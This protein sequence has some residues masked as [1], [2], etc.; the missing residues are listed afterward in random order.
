[1]P[2]GCAA[3]LRR[4]L[5]LRNA[6]YSVTHRLP[7]VTSYGEMPVVVHSPSGTEHGN[8]FDASYKCI[9]KQPGWKRRLDKIHTTAAHSPPKSARRWKELDSSM[10]SDALLMNILCCPGVTESRTVALSLG[11]EVG[12]VSEFGFRADIPRERGRV[13]RTEVD[14]RLGTLLAESKLTEIDFQIQRAAVVE[15]YRDFRAVFDL[16]STTEWTVCL[17]STDS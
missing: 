17:V 4:E 2:V 6:A 5:S 16:A 3:S 11:F 10:S 12:E 15:S 14:M 9:L 13:D 1:M 8:F 7:Y